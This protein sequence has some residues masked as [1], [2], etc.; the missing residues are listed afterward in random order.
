MKKAFYFL[1]LIHCVLLVFTAC[2]KDDPHMP[3][4]EEVITTLTY[5]LTPQGGGSE[6]V[7]MFKD[8]DGD[9]GN[10]PV[11]TSGILSSNTTYIGRLLLLNELETLVGN[12]TEEI[13]KEGAEHQFFFNSSLADLEINYTDK[14]VNDKPIGILTS[15]KTG[16]AGSGKLKIVLRHQPDKNAEGVSA[17]DISHAGGETDI[18]IT[19]DIDV[20]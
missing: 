17:G 18:E 2:D 12:I 8:I 9:G 19:F 13:V 11:I 6:V 15:V 20:Q 14:D 16:G 3:N 10:A 1:A 7:L 5:T 4:E